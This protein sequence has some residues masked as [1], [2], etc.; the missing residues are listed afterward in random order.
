MDCGPWDPDH[1]SLLTHHVPS[2]PKLSVPVASL[3]DQTGFVQVFPPEEE[4]PELLP[5]DEPLELPEPLPD[6]DPLELP[7]ELLPDD[8]PLPEPPELPELLPDDE[9][10]P[11]PPELLPDDDPLE[12][13]ELLPPPS[14]P[15][16]E[17][18]LSVGEELHPV[19][20]AVTTQRTYGKALM[21]L[22]LFIPGETEE[23]DPNQRK[24][25]GLLLL[26]AWSVCAS[27][28]TRSAIGHEEARA[29][30]SCALADLG[31]ACNLGCEE[32]SGASSSLR[33]LRSPCAW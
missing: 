32:S 10:L 3:L 17:P 13:P 33:C 11:E 16:A 18:P 25:G 21:S 9:P 19:A 28:T 14:S 22:L 7:E 31:P 4:P 27:C 15:C 29:T 1:A 24:N 23:H 2:L 5:E 26:R 12:P 8:E 30:I 6:D 20:T